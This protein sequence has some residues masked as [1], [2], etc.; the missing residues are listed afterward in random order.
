MGRDKDDQK[1]SLISM[2]AYQEGEGYKSQEC[3]KQEIWEGW[4]EFSFIYIDFEMIMV[5]LQECI[6][7]IWKLKRLTEGET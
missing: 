5:V 2:P 1:W 3:G 7:E 6:V 4:Q